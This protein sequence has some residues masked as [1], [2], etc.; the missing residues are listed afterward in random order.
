MENTFPQIEP[1]AMFELM[2]N[3]QV[4]MQWDE[5]WIKPKI[6]QQNADGSVI[7]HVN[8]PKPPIPLVSQRDLVLEMYSLKDV[9]A[10]DIHMVIAG[11]VEHA[12]MPA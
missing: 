6:L 5:R 4:R 11:S 8:T 3:I 10:Q 2:G 7:M 12:D 9:K 1:D